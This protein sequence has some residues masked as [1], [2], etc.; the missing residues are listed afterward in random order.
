MDHH[1]LTEYELFLSLLL[2]PK[3]PFKGGEGRKNQLITQMLCSFLVIYKY[4]KVVDS[5]WE[6][7]KLHF[8]LRLAGAAFIPQRVSEYE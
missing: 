1:A 5:K 6:W 7:N 2:C 3:A 8:G 4:A